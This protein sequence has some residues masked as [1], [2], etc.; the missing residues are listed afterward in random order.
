MDTPTSF[1][2]TGNGLS[3]SN[4]NGTPLN[5]RVYLMDLWTSIPYYVS[6]LCL[7]LREQGLDV[8]LCSVRYHLDGNYFHTQGLSPE[9]W[10]LDLGGRIRNSLLGR[11]V[12]AIEYWPNLILLAMQIRK[13]RPTILHVQSLR[14][15][16]NGFPFEIWFLHW[17][18]RRGVKI[19]YT[20][21]NLVN[22]ENPNRHKS[23]YRKAYQAADLLICHSPDTS[24]QLVRVFGIPSN[25]LQVIPH[26]PLFEHVPALSPREARAELGLPADEFLVLFIGIIRQYKGIPFLLEAWKLLIESG[27]KARLLI[28]GTGDRHLMSAIRGKVRE[29]G[30][31]SSVDLWLHYVSVEQL[32]LLHQAADILVYPYKAVTTSGALLTGLN[33]GKAVVATNL[34]FFQ[35]YLRDGENALLVDYR[36]VKGLACR[37]RI[38][39]EKP[40]ERARIAAVLESQHARRA[41]WREISQATRECYQNLLEGHD[42]LSERKPRF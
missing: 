32:P 34:S 1:P 15:L 36:D 41:S 3:T 24:A 17:V 37:L 20:V 5:A 14:F 38:L 31:E 8:R 23:L 27:H 42:Q 10:L 40:E 22:K 39:L 19:V 11:I 28:A 33:Y 9:P 12:K 4:Y 26:G 16:E 21:H 25:K 2:P 7:G 13:S 30:L 6:R 29:E 35:E 18:R